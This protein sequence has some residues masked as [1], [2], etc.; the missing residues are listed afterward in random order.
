[1]EAEVQLKQWGRLAQELEACGNK[2]SSSAVQLDALC[3]HQNRPEIAK[4]LRAQSSFLAEQA[5]LC[6]DLAAVLKRAGYLYEKTEES[7][8]QA[9]EIHTKQYE[10]TLR[11]VNLT[12]MA[13]FQVL[14]N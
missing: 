9:A 14:L 2:I 12:D 1:M 13:G 7:V 8:I 3:T 5:R 4:A 11:V 6:R 10:E